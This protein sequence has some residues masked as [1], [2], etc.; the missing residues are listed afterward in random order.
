[1]RRVVVIGG[2]CSGKTT[3]ARR[4]SQILGV[5][6]VELDALHHGPNWNEAPAD[7]LQE[8]VRAALEAAPEGWVVDGNYF[9][10]LGGFVLERA[11]TVV[12]LDVAYGTVV[13]RVLWRTLSRFV[14]RAELWNGNR[15]R[16]RDTF[17]RDSIVWWVLRMHRGFAAK[18]AGR[19]AEHPQLE[20]VR[21]HTPHE[22]RGWLQS[23]QATASTSGSS[24]GS[25]R[26][27][28]P[29]FVET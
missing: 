11:D 3:V 9:G 18:W 1:M 13:R 5:A 10:K 19:L 8:R 14:T 25:E 26:Q 15:E 24:N 12:W 22:I 7:V 2:S 27:K 28:T 23:I 4:L 16:L 17:G 20:I 29:P 6:H 21:L